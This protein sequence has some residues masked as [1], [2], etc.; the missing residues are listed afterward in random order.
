MRGNQITQNIVN[1]AEA[2]VSKY[3]TD[4]GFGNANVRVNLHEDLSNENEMLVDIV[5]NKNNKVK[6]HKIYIRR[7]RSPQRPCH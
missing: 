4:K 1:R 5:I 3:Y 7:K 6:V 2:I